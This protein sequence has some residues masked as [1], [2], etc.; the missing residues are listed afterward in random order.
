MASDSPASETEKI[1]TVIARSLAFLCLQNTPAKDG[2]LLEKVQF[3]NGLGL[4]YAD[5]AGMLGTTVQ[6]VRVQISQAK[7]KK[8]GKAKEKNKNR[9][10]R[11]TR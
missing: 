6:S 4:P 11:R 2:T 3:L 7:G 8:R 1:G 5:A 10:K 9:N